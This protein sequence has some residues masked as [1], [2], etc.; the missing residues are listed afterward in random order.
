MHV[1]YSR[2]VWPNELL[3][4]NAIVQMTKLGRDMEPAFRLPHTVTGQRRIGR[5]DPDGPPE[6]GIE[7]SMRET[8][9]LEPAGSLRD[10]APEPETQVVHAS[11]EATETRATGREQKIET[12]TQE[13]EK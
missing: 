9:M 4:R 11:E 2:S 5:S 10:I 7:S 3:M 12:P 1:R 6:T 8:P 13:S